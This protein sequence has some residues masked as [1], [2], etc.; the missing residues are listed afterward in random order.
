MIGTFFVGVQRPAILITRGHNHIHSSIST[1]ET[2]RDLTLSMPVVHIQ[3]LYTVVF[4][5]LKSRLRSLELQIL[6][7]PFLKKG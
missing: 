4:V 1:R 3:Q 7:T 2:V 5:E 6:E